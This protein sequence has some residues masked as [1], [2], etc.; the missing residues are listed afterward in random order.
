MAKAWAEAKPVAESLPKPKLGTVARFFPT[1]ECGALI[2]R[3][4][5]EYSKV[6][7]M[8]LFTFGAMQSNRIT[9]AITWTRV[10]RITQAIE[11]QN[12]RPCY[13]PW[14]DSHWTDYYGIDTSS[15]NWRGQDW[16]EDC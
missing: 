5:D 6:T 14:E 11:L 15:C 8:S 7:I 2:R 9:V 13:F 12:G 4:M 16:G 1:D 3:V 10:Q